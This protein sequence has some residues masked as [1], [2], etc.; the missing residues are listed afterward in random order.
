MFYFC[1]ITKKLKRKSGVDAN[2]SNTSQKNNRN[3]KYNSQQSGIPFHRQKTP[4][5]SDEYF[6]SAF[7][8][9]KNKS[10][11]SAIPS[12]SC[13]LP[14]LHTSISQVKA[15][16]LPSTPSDT[17]YTPVASI[18]PVM[19]TLSPQ[20]PVP[21]IKEEIP[22]HLIDSSQ[23][24]MSISNV[25]SPQGVALKGRISDEVCKEF[26]CFLFLCKDLLC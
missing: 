20:P 2:Q 11:S 17:F 4:D 22:S 9:S 7:K 8:Y 25:G 16:S 12:S 10:N 18:D 15:E 26:L 6:G 3:E 13:S 21:V 5:T 24:N 1:R 23:N 19:P 14:Q